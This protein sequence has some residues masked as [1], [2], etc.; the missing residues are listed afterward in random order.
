MAAEGITQAGPP[1]Y[2]EEIAQQLRL[3]SQANQEAN[4]ASPATRYYACLE[5][6]DAWRQLGAI[7][8][9]CDI[10]PGAAR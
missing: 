6:A 4:A 9:G 5:L 3:A 1:P 8:A 2:L 7:D 10:E